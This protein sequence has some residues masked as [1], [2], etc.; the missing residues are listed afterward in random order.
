LERG[1]DHVTYRDDN[2]GQRGN[3]EGSQLHFDSVFRN[4][5]TAVS[6]ATDKDDIL[7]VKMID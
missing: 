7:A 4:D 6:I 3:E 2:T 1:K 5:W